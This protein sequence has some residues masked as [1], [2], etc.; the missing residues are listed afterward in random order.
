VLTAGRDVFV[1]THAGKRP[2]A[3]RAYVATWALASYLMFDRRLLG[4]AALDEFVQ[5]VCSGAEPVAAFE[6]LVGQ[7]AGEFEKAFHGWLRR[8]LPNGALLEVGGK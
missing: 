4:T 6:G 3:D 5:A 8:L 7:P 2:E 1:V